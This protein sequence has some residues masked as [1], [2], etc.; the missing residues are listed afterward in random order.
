MYIR[1]YTRR[2]R[3]TALAGALLPIRTRAVPVGK[4]VKKKYRRRKGNRKPVFDDTADVYISLYTTGDVFRAAF[5]NARSSPPPH[6]E[7]C[8]RAVRFPRRNL[9]VFRARCFLRARPKIRTVRRR[10]VSAGS[11]RLRVPGVGGDASRVFRDGGVLV[12][13]TDD[14]VSERRL[15]R[16]T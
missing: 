4:N 11:R 14:Y 2:N 7:I 1:A 12:R 13:D 5:P 16:Y 10:P 15:V 6:R 9:T 3:G 8:P